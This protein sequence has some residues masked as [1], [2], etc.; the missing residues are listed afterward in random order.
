[1]A[2]L[3]SGGLLAA[4][5][6]SATLDGGG[7]AKFLPAAAPAPP[8]MRARPRVLD[9]G[10][11]LAADAGE[12]DGA[13]ALSAR[14]LRCDGSCTPVAESWLFRPRDGAAYRVEVTAANDGGE[15]V[16]V[17]GDGDEPAAP[18]PSPLADGISASPP[19]ASASPASAPSSLRAQVSVRL[20]AVSRTSARVRV[21]SAVAGR[22]LL[23]VRLAGGRHP[24]VGRARVWLRAGAA[25]NVRVALDRR[26]R[27]R[28]LVVEVV[29]S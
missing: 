6:G 28:K 29:P 23:R 17:S 21:R 22:V 12:W 13:V 24:V 1:M 18:D 25:R 19:A 10:D 7:V 8:V 16:A 2:P 9:G 3:P 27:H 26:A 4:A 11:L 5:W 14:W 20:L 15:T